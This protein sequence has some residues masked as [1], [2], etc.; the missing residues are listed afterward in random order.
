MRYL[1][2]IFV[3]LVAGCAQKRG[4]TRTCEAYCSEM[5]RV[6]AGFDYVGARSYYYRCAK[7][8]KD[9]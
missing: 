2:I 8:D 5:N 9:S 6:C 3:L 4:G 1:Y 7:K